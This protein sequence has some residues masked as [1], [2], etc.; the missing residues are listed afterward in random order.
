MAACPLR[1]LWTYSVCTML[2]CLCTLA[3]DSLLGFIGGTP[4]TKAE[5]PLTRKA[6]PLHL[7]CVH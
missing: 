3:N 2:H 1:G 4:E 7:S 6:C 5:T